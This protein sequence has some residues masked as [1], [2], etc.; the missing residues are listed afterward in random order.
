MAFCV[1][2]E[3]NMDYIKKDKIKIGPGQYF[4]SLDK[5][6][7]KKRMHPPFE[8]SSQKGIF[9][10]INDTPGPGSYNLIKNKSYTINKDS[11][12]LSTNIQNKEKEKNI[13]T[14]Y[15][16]NYSSIIINSGLE[17]NSS[18]SIDISKYKRNTKINSIYEISEETNKYNTI[19]NNYDIK[20]SD[21]TQK[22]FQFN[23]N[24]DF[25]NINN[26]NEVSD[27]VICD[28]GV[29]PIKP[30]KKKLKKKRAKLL[31]MPLKIEA[32]SLQRIISI[33][34]KEMNGYTYG[35]N[36]SLNLLI[37]KTNTNEYIGPG[38]YNIKI[39]KRP[40]N[41]LDWSKCLN[42]KEIKNKN[43]TKKKDETLEELKK[44]GNEIAKIRINKHKN[45][46]LVKS[47]LHSY[48]SL[49]GLND[50]NTKLFSHSM[51]KKANIL[52]YSNYSRNNFLLDK[53]EIPGPGYYNN[54]LF[55]IKKEN[56]KNKVNLFGAFGSNSNRFLNKSNSMFNIGP[57]SY[58]IEKNKYEKN[59]PD[60]F[61]K[62]K[63]KRLIDD[64]PKLNKIRNYTEKIECNLGPGTYNLGHTF[65]NRSF[66]N[67]QTM[68]TNNDRF[69]YF[70]KNDTP[71]PGTYT[72]INNSL[73]NIKMYKKFQKLINK[74][75][76][77][78]EK[79]RLEKL[80]SLKKEKIEGVP[81]VG[82][83]NV[84]KIDSISHKIKMKLNPKLS[85]YSPFLISSG[86]FIF[87]YNNLDLPIYNIQNIR[88]NMKYMAFSKAER[89]N[90]INKKISAGPGSDNLNKNDQWLK[91]TFNKLFS[92]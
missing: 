20:K 13:S 5:I 86:R 32:G 84:E 59:K 54:N 33:P 63:N 52:E 80:E 29:I 22:E 90:D 21:S 47:N 8:I 70:K 68:D 46:K 51:N 4:K 61:S 18:K 49:K 6:E 75:F 31:N 87:K 7:K 23:N 67:F 69:N 34:S 73:N 14:I 19:N 62:L 37:D 24:T 9:N 2:S 89:F 30:I 82:T 42:I 60:F 50:L 48:N 39:I 91:K 40:K 3:R 76:E 38:R 74:S 88:E 44:K 56:E 53:Y 79:K 72:Y 83:Y 36:K 81:G 55:S 26:N 27:Y 43:D 85:Y 66:S 16:K 45:L 77:E 64:I 10:K 15:N 12:F 28:Y 17:N 41:I 92:S 1:R 78:E 71:G 25:S 57:A 35:F 58:F 65:I 11:T